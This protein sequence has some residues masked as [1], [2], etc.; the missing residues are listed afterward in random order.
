MLKCVSRTSYGADRNTLLLLYRSLVRSRM[1]YAC[2]IYDSTYESTKRV[3]DS[4]HHSAI[5]IATGAFRTTPIASL[6]VEAHEPPLALRR[7]LLGLRY[8]LKL[9]QFPSHPTFKAVFSRAT[10]SVFEDETRERRGRCEPFCLRIRRLLADSGVQLR[11]VVRIRCLQTPPWQLVQPAVDT[12]LAEMKKGETAPEL[13]KARTLERIAS[14]VD[15]VRFYTDGSKTNDGVGCAFA[16]GSTIRSFTLP[17]QASVFT[18]ELVA[19]I[20]TLCFIEVADETSYL[21]LSDSLSSLLTLMSFYP[22]NPLAQEILQR[23]TDLTRSGKRIAF[24]WIP[25]HV[26]IAGNETADAGAKRATQRPC[27]RRLPLPAKDFFPTIATAARNSWQEAWD[28]SQTNKLYHLKPRLSTWHSALRKCR[29][30]E[31]SLCRL[32]TGHTHGTH[33]YLLCGADRP[34]C[35]RCGAV[36]SVHHVLLDC[37]QLEEER[38]RFLGASAPTLSMRGLLG[39]DSVFLADG[40]L[41]AFV[42][43]ANLSVVFKPP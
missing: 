32:R 18:S 30:E 9:R 35:P 17:T 39:D 8:A 2:F 22:D 33:G 24:C 20:K 23:H 34:V 3:L 31:V 5:R 13:F 27:S 16:C 43:A 14:Y 25:S 21:I 10:L 4:V 41:F 29:R 38:R 37:P 1:D 11:D 6:L 15:H 36:L 28:H 7:E 26:G 19:I 12:T 40:R 42:N